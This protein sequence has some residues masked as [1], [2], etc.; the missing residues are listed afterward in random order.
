MINQ[1]NTTNK[2]VPK[3]SNQVIGSSPGSSG[4]NITH[5]DNNPQ[6]IEGTVNNFRKKK[7]FNTLSFL[8]FSLLNSNTSLPTINFN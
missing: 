3:K 1:I 7:L 8:S 6:Q 5:N 2:V 4:I